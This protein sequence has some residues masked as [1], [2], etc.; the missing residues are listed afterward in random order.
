MRRGTQANLCASPHMATWLGPPLVLS[1]PT[2][3]PRASSWAWMHP[4]YTRHRA[5]SLCL[6]LHSAA[7]RRT[8][9]MPVPGRQ[10]DSVV[11]LP[12]LPVQSS[13]PHPDESEPLCVTTVMRRDRRATSFHPAS[14][15]RST[16][17]PP[18]KGRQ[19]A[20]ED[21]RSP[22]PSIGSTQHFQSESVVVVL[23]VMYPSVFP[24][25]VESN[26]HPDRV[27]LPPGLTVGRQ[28]VDVVFYDPL[29]SIRNGEEVPRAARYGW[30]S[31]GDGHVSRT[32][33]QKA[34]AR[35][36]ALL[37]LGKRGSHRLSTAVIFEYF[38]RPS[39]GNTPLPKE[40]W[41]AP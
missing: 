12:R 34:V 35:D 18:I 39:L 40:S 38:L 14:R 9:V 29:S 2:T 30:N 19:C 7:T 20:D 33:A 4:A 10:R 22:L 27:P 21:K 32:E 31:K 23:G 8:G 3:A 6:S 25:L 5:G 16:V 26:T 28:S 36:L 17:K 11:I 1:A 24:H 37:L 15:E 41:K 13:A